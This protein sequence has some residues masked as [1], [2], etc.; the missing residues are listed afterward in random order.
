MFSRAII[1]R[2]AYQYKKGRIWPSCNSLGKGDHN[3]YE[4]TLLDTPFPQTRPTLPFAAIPLS[5]RRAPCNGWGSHTGTVLNLS[6]IPSRLVTLASNS[7]WQRW[8]MHSIWKQHL[9]MYIFGCSKFGL[10]Y[11]VHNL[12]MKPIRVNYKTMYSFHFLYWQYIFICKA[13]LNV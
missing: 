4:F 7:S 2:T 5:R 9:S 12:N 10:L 8:R 3:V 1:V 11:V 6:F 13:E